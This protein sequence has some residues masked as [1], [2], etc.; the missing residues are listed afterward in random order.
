MLPSSGVP[1][2][3]VLTQQCRQRCASATAAGSVVADLDFGDSGA[4]FERKH[5]NGLAVDV[6]I[7]ERHAMPLQ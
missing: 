7:A 5:R 6:E 1:S 2:K 4:A 3:I